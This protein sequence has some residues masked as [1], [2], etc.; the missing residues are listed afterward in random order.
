MLGN[1]H[2][3]YGF[4]LTND[5]YIYVEQQR[6]QTWVSETKILFIEHQ[7]KVDTSNDWHVHSEKLL[8][9]EF[10]LSQLR[11]HLDHKNEAGLSTL[12]PNNNGMN[13]NSGTVESLM[14][15]LF[16]RELFRQINK[17]N[18][19]KTNKPKLSAF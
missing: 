15:Y 3:V 18:I 19:A 6:L 12:R 2:L 17:T 13:N 14:E 9:P 1:I 16:Q 5:T 10:L 4:F 11:L 8:E 7:L